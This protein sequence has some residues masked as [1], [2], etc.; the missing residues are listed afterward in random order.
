MNKTTSKSKKINNNQIALITF[1]FLIILTIA[2]LFMALDQKNATINNYRA[3]ENS[4]YSDTGTMLS[5]H[6]MTPLDSTQASNSTQTTNDLI[7]LIEEEKLAHDVY[8][9]L[10]EKWNLK[11]FYNIKN[12]ESSHQ[13]AL[14]FVMESRG[15]D[16]PRKSAVGE[17]TNPELQALYNKLVSQGSQSPTEAYKVGVAIEELDIKDLKNMISNLDP[18]D[19]DIAIVFD[20]LVNGSENHLK[21]F[22]KKL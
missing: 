20:N 13:Q 4:R 16:D 12:S 18:K 14:L 8:Q 2:W 1:G 15:I 5:D 7:C 22:T 21:A 17:F 6:D 11:S 19:T 10:Y 3:T 9:T